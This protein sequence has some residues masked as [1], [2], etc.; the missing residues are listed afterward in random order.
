MREM[1]IIG[2]EINS[3]EELHE[4]FYRELDLP[5]YYGANLDALYDVLTESSEEISIELSME[6]IENEAM[7]VYLEK[8]WRVLC[9]AAE[10]NFNLE[11]TRIDD[12]N[13]Y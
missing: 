3:P 10:E 7:K 1:Q 4:M 12:E 6:D 8:V 11:V 13:E 9:D 5:D 2:K